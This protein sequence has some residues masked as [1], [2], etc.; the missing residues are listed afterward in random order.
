[1]PTNIWQWQHVDDAERSS[2]QEKKIRVV[3]LPAE[4]S[5]LAAASTPLKNGARLTQDS[6]CI[7]LS[8]QFAF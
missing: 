7:P 8:V 1:M 2:V 4:G 5:T 3:Y 6:V